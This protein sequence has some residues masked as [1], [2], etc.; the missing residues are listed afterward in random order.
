MVDDAL[1][2]TDAG[3]RAITIVH[4]DVCSAKLKSL[5]LFKVI[6]ILTLDFPLGLLA[7][8]I[9]QL[10]RYETKNTIS[11][12]IL[13]RHLQLVKQIFQMIFHKRLSFCVACFYHCTH[14]L[15]IFVWYPSV[16][17]AVRQSHFSV[18]FSS[19]YISTWRIETSDKCY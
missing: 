14:F 15:D 11:I 1:H 17:P 13:Y 19:N 7:N 12:Y 16:L 5:A 6:Y 3:H 10:L 4:I 8:F 9:S 18:T 2:T